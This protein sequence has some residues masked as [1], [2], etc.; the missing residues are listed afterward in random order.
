MGFEKDLMIAK[1]KA[2]SAENKLKKQEKEEVKA[3]EKSVKAQ[4]E[5]QGRVDFW[6]NMVDNF[7]PESKKIFAEELLNAIKKTDKK[8]DNARAKA[9][10]LPKPVELTDDDQEMM[11]V[12]HTLTGAGLSYALYVLSHHF[13]ISLSAMYAM[14]FMCWANMQA[15]EKKPLNSIRKKSR[16][17][18]VKKLER[19]QRIYGAVKE[20]MEEQ[21]I[22][23]A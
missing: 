8:L 7:E 13:M 16:D 23:E 15:N 4:I 10:N 6:I 21:N 14:M 1:I 19:Q 5:E 2:K 11:F 17:N 9:S 12:M 22:L 18:K 3:I 20:Y